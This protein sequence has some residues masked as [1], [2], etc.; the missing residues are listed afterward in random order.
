[1]LKIFLFLIG[2]GLSFLSKVPLRDPQHWTQYNSGHAFDLLNE[3]MSGF[4][5]GVNQLQ[6][7]NYL[8][9]LAQSIADLDDNQ[10]SFINAH[11]T[12]QDL[13]VLVFGI[14]LSGKTTYKQIL[15]EDFNC[16]SLKI[17]KLKALFKIFLF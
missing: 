15:T 16:N 5:F 6:Q 17:F 9:E 7:D 11:K 1:M 12:E 14:K 2:F 8:T 13:N 4:N 10:H 3:W